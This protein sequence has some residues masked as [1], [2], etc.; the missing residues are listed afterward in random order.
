MAVT[1]AGAAWPPGGEPEEAPRDELCPEV[2]ASPGPVTPGGRAPKSFSDK[3]VADFLKDHKVDKTTSDCSDKEVA[4]FLT[5]VDQVL[6]DHE[7]DKTTNDC[8]DKEVADFLMQ[9]NE[10]IKDRKDEDFK[11]RKDK[12]E[13]T[14]GCSDQDVG[15]F[16]TLLD[17]VLKDYK[18][19]DKAATGT[20]NGHR[21]VTPTGCGTAPAEA[22]PKPKGKRV[23]MRSFKAVQQE[24]REKNR[25]SLINRATR[26]THPPPERAAS[27]QAARTHTPRRKSPHVSYTVV[28]SKEFMNDKLARG[29]WLSEAEGYSDSSDTSE[30]DDASYVPPTAPCPRCAAPEPCPGRPWR[31][32]L[33]A[34]GNGVGV[35]DLLPLHLQF[36]DDRVGMCVRCHGG[37]LRH[38]VEETRLDRKHLNGTITGWAVV[39]GPTGRGPPVATDGWESVVYTVKLKNAQE[40]GG[41][42]HSMLKHTV[43]ERDIEFEACL[44]PDPGDAG[45]IDAWLQER[46]PSNP[47]NRYP[48]SRPLTACDIREV[49][50]RFHRHWRGQDELYDR[51]A[52]ATTAAVAVPP[53]PAG[54]SAPP[55]G[56]AKGRGKRQPAPD[57]PKRAK[58]RGKRQPAHGQSVSDKQTNGT[59]SFLHSSLS[60]QASAE[61]GDLGIPGKHHS[62]L[63]AM[64]S[65]SVAPKLHPAAL[66]P[67][68]YDLPRRRRGQRHGEPHVKWPSS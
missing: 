26:P 52:A 50:T 15:D 17:G 64:P 49:A 67:A 31:R 66:S 53:P 47:R 54:G 6:K 44:L 34:V 5:M 35:R 56:R 29:V 2:E 61:H 19:K 42:D 59:P 60:P 12:D 14:S 45:A 41:L 62:R 51:L 57:Q 9:V 8:S 46:F 3:E 48:R 36:L 21:C 4:D 65:P 28:P 22:E 27:K 38:D 32:R 16:L 40:G 37:Q 33:T 13:T 10:D 20:T 1:P 7:V 24:A 63:A 11:D 25:A 43:A 39:P 55:T 18:D 68:D 58:G 30:E 23:K